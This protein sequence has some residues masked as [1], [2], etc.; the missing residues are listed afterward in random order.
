MNATEH[1][2][3]SVCQLLNPLPQSKTSQVYPAVYLT[4]PCRLTLYLD[5]DPVYGSA[6]IIP[7][8]RTQEPVAGG[9]ENWGHIG[10]TI[11]SEAPDH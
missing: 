9:I 7:E 11:V 4:V 5:H 6:P 3:S 1:S 2:M 8:V 10:N